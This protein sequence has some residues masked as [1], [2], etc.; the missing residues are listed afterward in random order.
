MQ[1]E[2]KPVDTTTW[3]DFEK[4]FRSKGGPSY[5]WCMAW[6]MNKEELKQ[7]TTANRYAFLK[8]RIWRGTPAGLLAYLD[9]EP[10]A[11]CSIAPR[12]SH[13]RLGG[14]ESLKNVW[15]ITCFYVKRE[16]R[17]MGLSKK[18]IAAAERYALENGAEYVEAYP[19]LP[20]SSSY[21]HMGFVK[22][23]EAAGYEFRK[24]AGSRRHVMAK[25]SSSRP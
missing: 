17:N 13:H 3:D 22:T 9:G 4:L 2:T 10:A 15:S 11:W 20:S 21:R 1:I 23:F 12:D 7:N 19:V 16:Y 6:R 18:L 25:R 5:C 8:Q 14:D 24:M